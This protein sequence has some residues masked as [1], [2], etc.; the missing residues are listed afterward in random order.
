MKSFSKSKLLE[1]DNG[2]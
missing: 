2:R 1:H